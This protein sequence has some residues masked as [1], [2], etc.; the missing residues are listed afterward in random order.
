MKIRRIEVQNFRRFREPV[1]VADL[2]D[3]LTVLAGENEAG[4][5]T[6]VRALQAAFF[7]RH[8]ISKNVA[9]AF[10]PFESEVQPQVTI[11]FE[12]GGASYRLRKGFY[13]KEFA[14]LRVTSGGAVYAD[15]EAEEKLQ[16]LLRFRSPDRGR[17]DEAKHH[18]VLGLL[19]LEQ[20]ASSDRWKT[21]L[22]DKD[23]PAGRSL[24]SALEAE[25]GE[26]LGGP[27]G[28]QLLT[29]IAERYS[30]FFGKNGRPRGD[31]AQAQTTIAGLADELS[32]VQAE[33]SRSET[34]SLELAQARK[35]LASFEQEDRLLRA[36]AALRQAE[37]EWQRVKSVES[38]QRQVEERKRATE[39]EVRLAAQNFRQR[40]SELAWVQSERG[41]LAEKL[42][43]LEAGQA[44][45]SD[46]QRVCAEAEERLAAAQAQVLGLQAML[47]RDEH[48]ERQLRL[49]REAGSHRHNLQQ[50][51]AAEVQ[52]RALMDRVRSLRVD[53][54]LLRQLRELQGELRAAE[55]RLDAVAT[56]VAVALQPGWELRQDGKPVGDA[57]SLLV[58]QKSELTLWQAG[59]QQ[60]ALTIH[61]GAEDLSLR[62]QRVA[63]SRQVLADRLK[64]A[65]VSDLDAAEA[66]ARER[67]A[68]LQQVQGL[69]EAFKA[70]APRG[71]D[72]LQA[73]LSRIEA[74]LSPDEPHAA[75]AAG[76]DAASLDPAAVESQL[77]ERI[78]DHQRQLRQAETAVQ[79]AQAGLRGAQQAALE[80]NDRQVRLQGELQSGQQALQAREVALAE[81]QGRVADAELQR[82][83]SEAQERLDVVEA[84]RLVAQRELEA[85]QPQVT[86]DLLRARQAEVEALQV[87]LAGITQLVARLEGEL[88]GLAQS[89]L[90]EREARLQSQLNRAR[91]VASQ[92][93]Q[94]AEALRLLQEVLRE[95]EHAAREN[96]ILPVQRRVERYLA[97]LFPDGELRFSDGTYAVSELRRAGGSEPF[98]A[99]SI[100]TREQLAVISRLAFADLLRDQGQPA[101][102]LFDDVLAFSDD[103]RFRS[104]LAALKDAAQTQQI[105]ILTCR[106]RD[107]ADPELTVREFPQR[108]AR[109]A[110]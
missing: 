68:L 39:V 44:L 11:D 3:G 100:G 98:D 108:S 83:L 73:E 29:R 82:A 42:A 31:Y 80:Q 43:A 64:D 65:G 1:V 105:L 92:Q 24:H 93:S 94:Q 106:G 56:R 86:S 90:R 7:D 5:S 12:C 107:Y 4:K 52:G 67:S 57:G 16:E 41:R 22:A 79:Q 47:R 34:A 62:Q 71:L 45:L 23:G 32:A 76:Q 37:A 87:E 8:S 13:L 51:R 40:Q 18:G 55:G 99:L 2:S 78:A 58:T 70:A 21:A 102:L 46:R 85:A 27:Y 97:R 54:A 103:R 101:C 66:Q 77:T 91:I 25:L 17:S 81:A 96:F 110:A 38:A 10:L 63:N 109:S 61:P 72:A 88:G 60:A 19:W 49:G 69:R 104:M 48:L 15:S 26:T 20:G 84:Q 6:L 50:A 95:S 30:E 28:H 35:R 89:D 75:P 59:R 53:D 33:L 36:R 9:K 74:Q 14:E